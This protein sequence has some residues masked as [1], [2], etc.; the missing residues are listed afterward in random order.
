MN[1]PGGLG[2]NQAQN[3]HNRK[4]I[5][6]LNQSNQ[7][8]KSNQLNQQSNLPNQPSQSMIQIQSSK[9]VNPDSKPYVYEP[10]GGGR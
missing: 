6:Q 3:N 8:N 4:H 10:R 1:Q 5:S 2:Q 9:G 7:S